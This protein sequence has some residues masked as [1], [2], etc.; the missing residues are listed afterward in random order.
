MAGQGFDWVKLE[1]MMENT[2]PDAEYSLGIRLRACANPLH[3]EMGTAHFF[4]GDATS[5]LIVKRN[6]NTVTVSYHGRNELPN[7]KDVNTTD[8]IR[9]AVVAAGAIAG[10]SE[11]Q[12]KALVKGFLQ[13][14]IGG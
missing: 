5:T 10:L 11:I 12:W 4:N 3:K 1:A 2:L 6:G 14:E 8:K 7:T 9:N 13:K